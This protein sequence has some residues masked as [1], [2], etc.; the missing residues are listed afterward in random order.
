MILRP[1]PIAGALDE[2]AGPDTTRILLDPGGRRFDQQTAASWPG[3]RTCSSFA[4]GTRAWTIA[5][6]RW[7]T[8]RCPSVTTC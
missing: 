8:S 3:T 4:R 1:E 6:G 5:S 7:S 2:L